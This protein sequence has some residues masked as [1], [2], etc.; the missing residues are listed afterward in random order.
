MTY[1]QVDAAANRFAAGL[2]SL[3]LRAGDKVA[4][5]LPNVPEFVVAYFGILRLG[6]CVVPI[7]T[8]LKANEIG[9][10]LEDSDAAALIVD[11]TLLPEALDALL[12]VEACHRGIVLGKSAPPGWH[13]FSEL[14]AMDTQGF[15]AAQTAPD[16][17]SVILYTAG[18]SGR[19][20]GAELSHF[21]T[22]FNA[23]VTADR[24]LRLTEDD[25]SLAVLPLFHAFGQTCVMNA[26]LYAAGTLVLQT[27]FEPERVLQAVQRH[28]V[29]VLLGVPT[30]FWY[31]LHYPS[32]DRYDWGSLRL[33]CSG[34]A[35]LSVDVMKEFEERYGLAIYEGYGLSETSPVASYNAAPS[36]RLDRSAAPP[37]AG[38]IGRP[39]YGVQMKI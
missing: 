34:G 39:I 20:K 22:F 26:T 16:T 23:V 2:A 37:R 10:Q 18:V 31:L 28:H 19:P 7:N 12:G 11:E 14:L 38:S 29:T 5:M 1:A 9:Y 4:L 33:C 21:N 6:G 13:L 35:A 25:V 17:T 30:M 24:L 15:D 32:A 27:R 3:G 36:S 8:L